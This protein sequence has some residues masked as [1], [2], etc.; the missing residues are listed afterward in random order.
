[1]KMIMFIIVFILFFIFY[2]ELVWDRF[3][4]VDGI[5]DSIYLTSF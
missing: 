3:R 5:L 1:M 2:F 4:D